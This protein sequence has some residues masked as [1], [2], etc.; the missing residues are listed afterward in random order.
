MAGVRSGACPI[1]LGQLQPHALFRHSLSVRYRP[2][3]Q[4]VK[5]VQ[6]P[7]TRQSTRTLRNR[8]CHFVV[9]CAGARPVTS[10][11]GV[12]SIGMFRTQRSTSAT[13]RGIARTRW[14]T[15]RTRIVAHAVRVLVLSQPSRR[16]VPAPLA[17]AGRQRIQCSCTSLT[18][19]S[20]F[21]PS[22]MAL[23]RTPGDEPA[24]S[25]LALR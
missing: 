24:R 14:D 18:L 21:A 23:N 22:N 17:P 2:V 9:S 20:R 11:F 25:R 7:R 15:R 6:R 12:T 10:T 16:P 19:S 1:A 5:D 3:L 8:R 13:T 4:A